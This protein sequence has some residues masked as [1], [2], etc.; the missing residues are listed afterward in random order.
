MDLSKYKEEIID[1]YLNNFSIHFIVEIISNRLNIQSLYFKQKIYTYTY[2]VL[3]E[4]G[5]YNLGGLY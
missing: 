4:E 1:M 2:D 5:I 3:I